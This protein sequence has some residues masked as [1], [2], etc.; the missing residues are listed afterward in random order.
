MIEFNH[1]YAFIQL[2]KINTESVK[3]KK[4]YSNKNKGKIKRNLFCHKIGAL[5]NRAHRTT[6]LT[7]I[8]TFFYICKRKVLDS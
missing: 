6:Y 7:T 8:I 2:K 3:K 1:L 5:T 4:K